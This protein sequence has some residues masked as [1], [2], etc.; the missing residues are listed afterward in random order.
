MAKNK[1][2]RHLKACKAGFC[3]A[4][5]KRVRKNLRLNKT[6]KKGDIIGVDDDLS[7][8]FVNSAVSGLPVKVFRKKVNGATKTIKQWTAD[9]EI[10]HFFKQMFYGKQIKMKKFI[11]VLRV[12][13]DDE[14]LKFAEIKGIKFKPNKKDKKVYDFV[15]A[16]QKKYPDTKSKLT[17]SIETINKF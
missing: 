5:E 2:F 16:M 12:I 14:A 11:S 3:R 17:K 15:E 9:D 7:Y 4:I 8:Y 10:N 13:T 1:E 6:F